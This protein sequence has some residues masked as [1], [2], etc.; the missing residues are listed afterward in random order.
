MFVQRKYEWDNDTQAYQQ[1]KNEWDN[2]T[3]HTYSGGVCVH[4]DT[5]SASFGYPRPRPVGLGRGFM[6]HFYTCSVPTARFGLLYR[7]ILVLPPSDSYRDLSIFFGY[8]WNLT[9]LLLNAFWM[10]V[11]NLRIIDHIEREN[12]IIEYKSLRYGIPSITRKF[13]SIFGR[14]K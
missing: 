3:Q 14:S 4:T 9:Y 5:L 12:I 7:N 11:K 2:A 6:L 10:H 13:D 1:R 8:G